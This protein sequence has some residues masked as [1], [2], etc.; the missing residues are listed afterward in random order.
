MLCA[1]G[2]TV[3]VTALVGNRLLYAHVYTVITTAVIVCAVTF[4]RCWRAS[5]KLELVVKMDCESLGSL[6][7][8][9]NH[10][11]ETPEQLA[12]HSRCKH[13]D[14]CVHTHVHGGRVHV[15]VRVTCVR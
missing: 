9:W 6:G 7:G 4:K 15:G 8:T 13:V 14:V 2:A 10:L 5:E 12:G 1:V 3:T 11:M